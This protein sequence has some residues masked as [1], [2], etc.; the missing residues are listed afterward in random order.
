MM[1]NNETKSITTR[2]YVF[3]NFGNNNNVFWFC[4]D[5]H[6]RTYNII[7]AIK[8]VLLDDKKNDKE[9]ISF[10]ENCSEESDPRCNY[11]FYEVNKWPKLNE[12]EIISD[13]IVSELDEI[14]SFIEY[15]QNHKYK[16]LA[17]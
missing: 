1:I 4:R 9:F 7:N 6:Y 3:D 13:D 15:F 17:T 12:S 8:N 2:Q 5:Y 10:L 11:F 16:D 14:K